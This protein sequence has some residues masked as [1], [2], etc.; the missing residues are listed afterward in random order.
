VFVFCTDGVSEARDP[1]G[2]EF[3]TA[4]LLDIVAGNCRKTSREQVDAIFGEAHS[5]TADAPAHDDMTAVVV[6]I[7][8]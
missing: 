6:K 2:R 1:A 7:T 8:A 3:G 4:R 5:F